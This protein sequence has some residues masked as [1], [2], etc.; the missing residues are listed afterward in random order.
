MKL[1]FA[2]ISILLAASTAPAF[3]DTVPADCT[4]T[5]KGETVEPAK[6]ECLFSQRQGFIDIRFVGE[7]VDVLE[8]EPLE[9]AG[10]FKD[11]NGDPAY[12]RK[13][14]GDDG[15]VFETTQGIVRVYWSDRPLP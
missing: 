2:A 11:Q 7:E 3:A 6:R 5:P 14:L 12:R 10:N 8:L 4:I 1:G 9:G 13:G 15:Q